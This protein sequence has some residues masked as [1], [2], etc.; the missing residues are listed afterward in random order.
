M[1]LILI[2]LG[3]SQPPNYLYNNI[4]IISRLCINSKKFF[5]T[6]N[7]HINNNINYFDFEVIPAE[8]IERSE[9]SLNLENIISI[10]KDFRNGF[11]Q[12]TS[13]R[14]AILH[15]FIKSNNLINNIHIENDVVLYKDPSNYL[16]YFND[17]GG[18]SFPTVYEWGI[19]SIVWIRNFYFSELLIT[20]FS[21][22][23][24]AHDMEN[25]GIFSK[26]YDG[27]K[28][29]PTIPVNAQVDNLYDDKFSVLNDSN[30]IFDAAALGQYLG[31]VDPANSISDSLFFINERTA[32]DFNKF[33]LQW[34]ITKGIKYPVLIINNIKY[35]IFN[36]HIHSKKIANFSP[37]NFY[38]L[39][40]YNN[41]NSF[42]NIYSK[43]DICI[44][45]NSYRSLGIN[46]S[47]FDT[48]FYF[49]T[50]TLENKYLVPNS[51]DINIIDNS[52]CIYI[53]EYSILFFIKL[54]L[55]RLKNSHK[56]VF[57]NNSDLIYNFAIELNSQ[58]NLHE[59]F[60]VNYKCNGVKFKSW[61][62][63]L[64]SS[65]INFKENHTI[66]SSNLDII[67]KSPIIYCNRD[68]QE[69]KIYTSQSKYLLIFNSYNEDSVEDFTNHIKL[70]RS[71]K[72]YFFLDAIIDWTLL[73]QCLLFNSIPVMLKTNRHDAFI[74]FPI[75][76]LDN[77]QELSN[78]DLDKLYLLYSSNFINLDLG[79]IF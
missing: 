19:G 22:N 45:N 7:F 62:P 25:L 53:E 27:F 5:I 12:Y 9:E 47:Y 16:S 21:Q 11:W 48:F 40:Y 75:I 28:A 73:Q 1:N 37:Y 79:S 6:N 54:I 68:C 63:I 70:L 23:V 39:E 24:N 3:S 71:S 55:F 50:T 52:Y 2:H 30:I 41:I 56:L 36:L 20:K 31:G 65:Y 26:S 18:I 34:E 74:E 51:D 67:V 17:F 35:E 8:F 14:F 42:H 78:I 59:I 43:S 77:W 46:I 72:F 57:Y 10:D 76:F 61:T 69:I 33:Q 38:S 44:L 13:T 60:L 58:I 4:E 29:L 32:L 15:D 49:P 64:K 66:I